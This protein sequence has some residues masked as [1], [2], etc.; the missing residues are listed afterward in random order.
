[1]GAWERPVLL[2]WGEDDRLVPV[3]VAER[4]NDAIAASTLGLVPDSG[5]LL[6]DDAFASVGEM[7]VEYLRAR[8]LRAP[9]DHG[10]ITMLQL[11]RRPPEIDLEL[12]EQDDGEPAPVDP[13]QQEVGPNA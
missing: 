11:E 1:M 10:G 13:A 8:Y 4:L 5:H 2:L 6:L 3:G 7:I 12:Y 9:H